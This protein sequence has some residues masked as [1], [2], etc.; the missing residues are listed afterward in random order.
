M[1]IEEMEK[2]IMKK[3]HRQLT[4]T[5]LNWTESITSCKVNSSL[6]FFFSDKTINSI[7]GDKQ[8]KGQELSRPPNVP[9]FGP[10]EGNNQNSGEMPKINSQQQKP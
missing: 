8:Q 4:I 2:I 6:S 3:N 1:K 10:G 7:D 5:I 9:S